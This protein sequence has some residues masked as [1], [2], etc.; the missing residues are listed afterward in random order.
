MSDS[1]NIQLFGIDLLDK[2]LRL[3]LSSF[4][5]LSC[6]SFGIYII[7]SVSKMLV[8]DSN[9][10]NGGGRR[11]IALSENCFG[12]YLFQQFVLVLI[13]DSSIPQII[14]PFL[15]PWISFAVALIISLLLTICIRKTAIGRSIL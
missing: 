1:D 4:V 15:L 5:R 2:A 6:A 9:L 3:S 10:V 8:N 7:Y 11:I 14:N 12:V 13:Y